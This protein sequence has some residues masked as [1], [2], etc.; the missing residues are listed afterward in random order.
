MSPASPETCFPTSPK[1]R[2]LVNG[3]SPKMG[4]DGP[5]RRGPLRFNRVH[6]LFPGGEHGPCSCKVI[7]WT[8]KLA[9]VRHNAALASRSS[10]ASLASEV[11]PSLNRIYLGR[12]IDIDWSRKLFPGV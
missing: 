12:Q 8:V 5:E 11:P 2:L 3:L 7:D 6:S 10:L 1:N 9:A 4:V